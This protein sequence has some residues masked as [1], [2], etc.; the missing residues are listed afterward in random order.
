M[1]PSTSGSLETS[2][3][4]TTFEAKLRPLVDGSV[5]R[6]SLLSHIVKL[7]AISQTSPKGIESSMTLRTHRAALS[8]QKE[9][10]LK[11]DGFARQEGSQDRKV[12]GRVMSHRLCLLCLSFCR[13]LDEPRF[14]L[15]LSF[16][17]PL[18]LIALFPLVCPSSTCG[19]QKYQPQIMAKE[20]IMFIL[21]FLSYIA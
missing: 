2:C 18:L 21:R 19:S 3:Q 6:R 1:K 4:K 5:G 12:S 10:S 20:N 15:S 7:Y 16:R 9:L 17:L 14:Q 11:L 8:G 13:I